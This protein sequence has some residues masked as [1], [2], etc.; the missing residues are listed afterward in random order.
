VRSLRAWWRRFV[1]LFTGDA[2]DR[3]FV[4]ELE[5]HL[6]LHVDDNVR[7]GMT[8][9][10]A[11]RRAL[12]ALGGVQHTRERYH[13]RRTIVPI[14][15]LLFDL[16]LALRALARRRLFLAAA[17]LSIAIGVGVNVAV[18]T[19]LQTVLF[20]SR[21]LIASNPEQLV[22]VSGLSYLNFQDMQRSDPAVELA[23]YTMSRAIWRTPEL[24]ASVGVHAV[25]D[26]FFEL[27]GTR[28]LRGQIFKAAAPGE[29]ADPHRVL[30]GY[31]FWQRLGGSDGIVGQS[32]T[33]NGWSYTV[34]GILPPEFHLSVGPML[35]SGV[36]VPI[37]P[38]IAT[39]LDRR[40]AN[41]FDIIG[42][43]R[44]GVTFSQA[45]SSL[46]RTAE[47][48][49]AGFPENT[50]LARRLAVR[51]GALNPIQAALVA[52]QGR[53]VLTL[54]AVAYLLVGL[55]LL[56]ACA[57][58]ASLLTARADE[59]RHETAVRIALGASRGRLI[60][61][62]LAESLIVAL[63]GTTAAA[64]V[65]TV[66][67]AILPTLTV[68][69]PS[70]Q[71]VTARMPLLYSAVL[72]VIVAV[73]CGL[74]PALSS[75]QVAPV[76]GLKSGRL[77]HVVSGLRLQNVLVGAQV[78][79]SFVLL[80]AAFVLLHTFLL[81]RTVAPG[82]DVVHTAAVELTP[83]TTKPV[84]AAE[85]KIA[86][87]AL[88]GVV[89]S[90]FGELPLGGMGILSR[91]TRIHVVSSGIDGTSEL[92]FGGTRYLE[93]M[94][95]PL[96]RGRDLA[97][98]DLDSR[99]GVAGTVVNETFVRKY[100]GS[101]EPLGQEILLAGDAENGRPD[102][103]LRIVGVA[104]DTKIRSLADD[105]PVVFLARRS[106]TTVVRLRDAAA[107]QA[108]A[109]ERTIEDRF[110]GSLVNVRPMSATLATALLP[111]RVIASLLLALGAIGLTLAMI[112]L[113]GIVSYGVT[114][115]WFEIGVRMALGAS[116]L[117]VV[118]LI[119]RHAM[120]VVAVGAAIGAIVSLIVLQALRPLLAIG[121]S[122][123]DPLAIAAV[124]V[125]LV[126]A[127]AVASLWPARRA[128]RVDPTV[129]LRAE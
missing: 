89:V 81:L 64:I 117:S 4:N 2:A 12:L 75:T 40:E 51:D 68:F 82:Y 80:T 62:S 67:T 118:N 86:V 102:R 52:P 78:A 26:N 13:E 77:G 120:R 38:A 1:A 60:Q 53:I 44:D 94:A 19:V 127:G 71:I 17:V 79:F 126:A 49:A 24:S 85:F 129:A 108:R 50:D 34:V 58:V 56:I 124:A 39:A 122:A 90:S 54:A 21:W 32:V 72:S 25:S 73:A 66:V 123:V 20:S 11:R 128:V 103:R 29:T 36:Y 112:G 31:G 93:T 83:V 107:S 114:R 8:P 3:E 98:E 55:V 76:A 99:N 16:R 37:S 5:S 95:M 87:D 48:V 109:I 6:D 61:Q 63:L 47:T 46:K 113:H 69:D 92:A 45:A 121:Q 9:T 59:R 41:Y 119:L 110:P 18:Y 115:R 104:R 10:E 22:S 100:L 105:T 15:Q 42:R 84:S 116:R 33:L 23:A 27:M 14:E 96:D 57:N 70:T 74:A 35:S 97:E 28:A 7:A 91:A 106:L 65:W 101:D 88:P 125:T 111:S 43:R 30:L